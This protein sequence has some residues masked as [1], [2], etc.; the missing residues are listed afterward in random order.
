MQRC[1]HDHL[2]TQLHHVRKGERNI[3]LTIFPLPR[4][5]GSANRSITIRSLDMGRHVGDPIKY[6]LWQSDYLPRRSNSTERL[7]R[8]RTTWDVEYDIPGKI[9]ML[10]C[11]KTLLRFVWIQVSSG[12]ASSSRGHSPVRRSSVDSLRR[13]TTACVYPHAEIIRFVDEDDPQ[14]ETKICNSQT[15][16]PV[17]SMHSALGDGMNRIDETLV[18]NEVRIAFDIYCPLRELVQDLNSRFQRHLLFC[19]LEDF[20]IEFVHPQNGCRSVEIV[21]GWTDIKTG[22]GRVGAFVLVDLLSR[23]YEVLKWLLQPSSDDRNIEQWI[24]RLVSH[25]LSSYHKFGGDSHI[26]GKKAWFFLEKKKCEMN[27]IDSFWILKKP[28]ALRDAAPH[29]L[30]EM[31]QNDAVDNSDVLAER[32]VFA[33]EH[34]MTAVS[35]RYM[36]V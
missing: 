33:F 24:H 28:F 26:N 23:E 36:N 25:R 6:S 14:W 31:L 11:G 15:G 34:P 18:E 2:P 35:I 12:W 29:M 7:R 13:Q 4:Q 9:L 17:T 19:H 10:Q 21:L 8:G 1:T 27:E 20:K 30:E 22:R 32:P 16:A 3:V 5:L